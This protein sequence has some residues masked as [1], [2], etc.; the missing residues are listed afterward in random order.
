M[1]SVAILELAHRLQLRGQ[2]R[3]RSLVRP[4][5]IPFSSTG[6]EARE[7]RHMDKSKQTCRVVKLAP[8]LV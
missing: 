6:R 7:N 4:H 8:G 1:S 3:L 2:L 5:R